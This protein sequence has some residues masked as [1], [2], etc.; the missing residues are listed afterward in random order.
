MGGNV[1]LVEAH[2]LHQFEVHPE[3]LGLFHGDDAVL[4]DLV[5]GLGDE[6]A[7]LGVSCGDTRDLGDLALGLGLPGQGLE[8]ADRGLYACLD[9]LAQAHRV[10][11]SRYVAQAL[12]DHGPCQDR[13]GRRAVACYVIGLLGDLFDQLGTNLFKR[14]FELDLF[15]D[16]DTVVGDRGGSPLLFQH[17]VA[18]LGAQRDAYC[19]GQLVHPLLKGSA[20]LF[21]KSN[22]LGHRSCSSVGLTGSCRSGPSLALTHVEC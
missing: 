16:R 18:A 7:D 21:V 4:A 3:G 14:V 2:A 20:G 5:D 6:L 22:Q 12:V 8:A 19:V 13:R 11:A 10:G 1:A 9:P 15:R 17:H